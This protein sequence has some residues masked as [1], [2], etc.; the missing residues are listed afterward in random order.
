MLSNAQNNFQ[1]NRACHQYLCTLFFLAFFDCLPQA[2]QRAAKGP[3]NFRL[4]SALFFASVP[5]SRAQLRDL[6]NSSRSA[7]FLLPFSPSEYKIDY[8]NPSPLSRKITAAH[9][10]RSGN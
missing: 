5:L 10:K 6:L 4:P 3:I 2:Q 9:P 1:D 7:L 8:L